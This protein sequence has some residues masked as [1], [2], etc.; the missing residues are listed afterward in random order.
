MSKLSMKNAGTPR[1]HGTGF[2]LIEALIAVGAM[3]ILGVLIATV[4]DTTGQTIAQGKRVSAFNQRASVMYSQLK[5]DIDKM[6]RDGC[7]VIRHEMLEPKTTNESGDGDRIDEM[8][9]FVD[10]ADMTSSREPLAD[11]VVARSQTARVYYGHGKTMDASGGKSYATPRVDDIPL[12]TALRLGSLASDRTVLRHTTLLMPT[13][14]STQK[15]PS[16]NVLGLPPSDPKLRDSRTQVSL[17][18]AAVSVFRVL[19]ALY[20]QNSALEPTLRPTNEDRP[21]FASGLVDIATQRLSEI[22]QIILTSSVFPNQ[23]NANTFFDVLQNN[24]TNQQANA[25][26]DGLFQLVADPTSNTVFDDPD[27]M[28]R[29]QAWMDELLPAFSHTD[30]AQDRTRIRYEREPLNFKGT[31]DVSDAV[32]AATRRTDQLALSS[33][34]FAPA[35]KELII[36]WSLG[37]FYPEDVQPEYLKGQMIWYGM[38][39]EENGLVMAVPYDPTQQLKTKSPVTSPS[40]EEVY[41]FYQPYTQIDGTKID[42]VNRSKIV[43]GNAVIISGVPAKGANYVKYAQPYPNFPNAGQPAPAPR[44]I[45]TVVR[46]KALRSDLIHRDASSANAGLDEFQL[47][48]YFGYVD[49]TFY[50]DLAP[51]STKKNPDYGSFPSIEPN[52]FNAQGDGKLE[53]GEDSLTPTIEWPWPKFIRVTAT[54]VDPID[55]TFEQTYQWVF[56]TPVGRR[57]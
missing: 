40:P 31:L 3:A 43:G 37:Q 20:P 44:N 28:A 29:M 51:L 56:E 47:T 7:L 45:D 41:T 36:E 22:R 10:N 32:L 52:F 19:N 12:P 34:I 26:V 30:Q 15:G 5:A 11:G 48:S 18:P 23:V 50:P 39:R 27:V 17:M 4:F 25:G 9:M 57:D 42:G 46:R 13:P 24:N 6:T 1:P 33:S 16:A 8:V 14:S 49:P 35:C 55:P 54:L 38:L 53:S 2:T 21:Q